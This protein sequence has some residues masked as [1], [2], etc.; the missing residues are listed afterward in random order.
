MVRRLALLFCLLGIAAGPLAA[1]GAGEGTGTGHGVILLYHRIAADGPDSTR[2]APDRFEAHLDALVDGGYRVLPLAELL[3][4]ARAGTLPPRAVAL[5]FDDAYRSILLG[6]LPLLAERGL[7]F[8][9]FVATGPV[10]AGFGSY[11]S[12]DELRQLAG[13]GLATFG[14]HSVSHGHLEA[15]R[16]GEDDAGWRSRVR[17]EIVD[18]LERLKSE[19]GDA[20][21]D[22][23]AHPYGE[24]SRAT[25]S[26]LAA[27]GLWGLAQQSGAV[28]PRV[29]P[30]R[31]PR[32][33]LYHGADGDARLRMALATR[34]LALAAEAEPRVYLPPGMASPTRW[35][36]RPS[37]GAW[38]EQ[39]LACYAADGRPLALSRSGAWVEVVLPEFR[40]G[41][42]K[43]NCTAPATGGGYA[44]HAR[45]W[46]RA[47][48]AGT[49]L[50]E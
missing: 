27:E 48:A 24:Y 34:P 23:H 31:V 12:W 44:W 33:P 1:G 15:R 32:F 2:V 19:L 3:A 28:G 16:D 26:L 35:R 42:N 5:T 6:A 38:R 9:V 47:D 13:S 30:T 49:W 39:G 22:A 18:S 14:G 20:V 4:G 41:R 40:P 21:I 46:V 50:R 29:T 45:L 10:D 43:V 8:T 25:E 11:L 17:G 36:F 7:P 37:P